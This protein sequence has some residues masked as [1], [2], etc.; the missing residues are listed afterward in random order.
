MEE[1]VGLT[2]ELTRAKERV[3]ACENAR[4]AAKAE[5]TQLLEVPSRP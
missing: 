1:V 2:R 3:A 4:D 5:T